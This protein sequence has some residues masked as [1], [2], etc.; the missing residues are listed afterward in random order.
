MEAFACSKIFIKELVHDSSFQ[1]SINKP[2]DLKKGIKNLRNQKSKKT[3][4]I[5][6][7]GTNDCVLKNLM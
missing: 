7:N 5:E 1:P 6:K 2:I 4:Y 3:L